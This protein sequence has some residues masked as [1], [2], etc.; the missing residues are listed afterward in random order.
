MKKEMSQ[1]LLVPNQHKENLI[2]F[3]KI[4]GL[5][6]AS[7]GVATPTTNGEKNE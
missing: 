1:M 2:F 6:R 4:I 7:F 3:K 5:H